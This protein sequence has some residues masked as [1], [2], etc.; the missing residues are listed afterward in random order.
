MARRLGL[1]TMAL[2]ALFGRAAVVVEMIHRTLH[3]SW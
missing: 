3:L 2:G 1:R